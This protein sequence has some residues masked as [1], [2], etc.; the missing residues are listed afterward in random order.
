MR[1]E[2]LGWHDYAV[3][4]DGF[5]DCIGKAGKIG[6]DC[7]FQARA[8]LGGAVVWDRTMRDA[9]RTWALERQR[10]QQ[11]QK[12]VRQRIDKEKIS[13]LLAPLPTERYDDLEDME[14]YEN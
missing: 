13:A 11:R 5:A 10:A 8:D 12:Q 7:W 3:Y 9:V 6:D 1:F 2:K 4:V 14:D